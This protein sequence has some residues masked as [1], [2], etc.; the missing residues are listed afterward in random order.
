MIDDV[1]LS[2]RWHAASTTA[3]RTHPTDIAKSLKAKLD[4]QRAGGT[5]SGA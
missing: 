1:L 5:M 2:K 3:T 4:R